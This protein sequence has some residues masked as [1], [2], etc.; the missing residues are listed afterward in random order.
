MFTLIV[1]TIITQVDQQQSF[2][3]RKVDI[4]DVVQFDTTLST[5]CKINRLL[6]SAIS[7][8]QPT[9]FLRKYCYDRSHQEHY[10]NQ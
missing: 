5:V 2:I 10:S 9:K 7:I 4:I 8:L 6:R 3:F 1:I